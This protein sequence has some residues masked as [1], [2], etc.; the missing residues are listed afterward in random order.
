MAGQVGDFFYRKVHSDWIF[1]FLLQRAVST[2]ISCTFSQF[3]CRLFLFTYLLCFI[4]AL[5]L[6]RTQFTE[7]LRGRSASPVVFPSQ[8]Y[9]VHWFVIFTSS[10]NLSVFTILFFKEIY[11]LFY[12]L[13]KKEQK[14]VS[15]LSCFSLN[16]KQTNKKNEGLQLEDKHLSLNRLVEKV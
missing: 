6:V 4:S 10:L 15:F 1:D 13:R 11:C 16:C 9:V 8:I 7:N 2:L 5:I 3:P 12:I 14:R